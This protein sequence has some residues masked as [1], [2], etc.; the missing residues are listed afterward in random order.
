MFSRQLLISVLALQAALP[1]PAQASEYFYRYTK[2]GILTSTG[3]T[4]PTNPTDPTDPTQSD[5]SPD[6]ANQGQTLL[7]KIGSAI[8]AWKPVAQSGW[9]AAVVDTKDNS[10]WSSSTLRYSINH[11][12]SPYGLSFSDLTGLISGTPTQAFVFN[13]FTVAVTDGGKSDSTAPFWLGVQP[14]AALSIAANQKT[15]YTFRAGTGFTTNPIGVNNAVGTLKFSKPASVADYGWD[16][17]NG[18]L[19]WS[20]T[21]SGSESFSTTISDEFN[22]SLPFSFT[23]NYLPVISVGQ[24]A[25]L[26][27]VGTWNYDGSAT[28]RKPTVDGILGT[29][30]WFSFD[31]PTGLNYNLDTGAISGAVTDSSQQGVHNVSVI[32]MDDADFSQGS[33]TLAINVLPPFRA[34]T[35]SNVS[36][37]QGSTMSPSGFTI[38]DSASGSPYSKSL[39]WQ[40]VSG[41]L[42]PGILT[43]GTGASFTFSGK[44]TAQGTFTSNWQATDAN[45]WKLTLDPITF[46]ISAR[47]PLSV[48]DI[49]AA[50]AVGRR[51]YTAADPLLTAT[52]QNVMGSAT[53]AATGLPAGLTMNS[54]TGAITGTISSGAEQGTQKFFN[55]TVTDSGDGSS[56][57]K[58]GQLAVNA[59]FTSL[60]YSPIGLKV[61][62]AM[63]PGGWSL[64]DTGNAPY[65]GHGVT[66]TLAA[67]GLPGGLSVAMVND[68]LQLSGTPTG[69]GTFQVQYTVR[70]ADG[71]S[72]TLPKI[73][74]TVAP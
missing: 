14:A 54:S 2:T 22:R 49:A 68:Q 24:L 42:P 10:A 65:T 25:Q 33:G 52:A 4:A 69:S 5:S 21:Q 43:Q 74:F 48:N 53:W 70:D 23:I 17:S 20:S 13:D 15:S 18:V 44:P 59:P 35:F 19:N 28:I 61:G 9:P 55:V 1:Y 11:D 47:D 30:S 34:D 29:P 46:T 66:Y 57:S 60:A 6:I 62:T 58:S 7:G 27:I 38:L 45:G 56:T 50:T 8:S 36:L 40:M 64:R 41:S 16:A 71:W 73:L 31:E 72:L 39:N 37:K 51:T 63:T 12:L 32:V 26:D 3:S 67:G